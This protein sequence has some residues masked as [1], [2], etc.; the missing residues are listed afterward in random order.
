[1]LVASPVLPRA[2]AAQLF[3]VLHC[4]SGS[5]PPV[6]GA[7][8][9][10]TAVVLTCYGPLPHAHLP[11][12]PPPPPACLQHPSHCLPQKWVGTTEAAA[13]LRYFGLR[14]QIVDFG[15]QQTHQAAAAT[16][17]AAAA[18][19]GAAVG[20][21]SGGGSGSGGSGG[22]VPVHPNVECDGC[23]QCPIRGD[24]FRSQSRADYDLCA[25]CHAAPGAAAAGPFV[26]MLPGAVV[27][28]GRGPGAAAGA[29][30]SGD[31]PVAQQLLAWVWRYFTEEGTDGSGTG[32][33]GI[34]GSWYATAEG[35][36]AAGAA[37]TAAVQQPGP[38]RL[39]LEQSRVRL[40]GKP[41]LYFQVRAEGGRVGQ[42]RQRRAV[43]GR[44]SLG[45]LG[46]AI[47]ELCRV[48]EG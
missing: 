30:S 32:S 27:M 2:D 20:G 14:A 36:T 11:P 37:V 23:G 29:S 47:G 44:R 35:P 41:P 3:L 46:R 12:P 8:P 28:A 24:R 45:S 21:S 22:P 43:K 38:K 19:T 26:R 33:G 9:A 17:R 42:A 31:G 6:L 1:V 10:S 34:D 16:Q 39:R 13:L 5:V 4:H 25:A 40:S 15:T 18:G 48:G 7:L